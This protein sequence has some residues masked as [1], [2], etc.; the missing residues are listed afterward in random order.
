MMPT[1]H[2]QIL[3]VEIRAVP[4]GLAIRM[5][6]SIK[7]D[8]VVAVDKCQSIGREIEAAVRVPAG[9]VG[10]RRNRVVLARRESQRAHFLCI[11]TGHDARKE[12]LTLFRGGLIQAC[13]DAGGVEVRTRLRIDKLSPPGG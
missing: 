11:S 10:R 13:L 7:P 9:H 12:R 2:N 6:A 1:A 3:G 4:L 5:V 8:V